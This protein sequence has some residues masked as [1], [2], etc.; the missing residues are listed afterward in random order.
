MALPAV[1]QI[2]GGGYPGQY[3]GGQY[4]GGQYPGGQYPGGR[5]PGGGYPGAGGGIPFPRRKKAPAKGQVDQQHPLQ[6]VSGAFRELDDKAITILTDDNLT[7]SAK[8]IEKT[9]FTKKG[10]ESADPKTWKPGDHVVIEATQDEQGFYY[11]VNVIFDRE[12]TSAEREAVAGPPP[13]TSAKAGEKETPVAKTEDGEIIRSSVPPLEDKPMDSDDPGRPRIR[14]GKPPATP[15]SPA[16]TTTAT[17]TASAAPPKVLGEWKPTPDYS[18]GESNSTTRTATPDASS[19]RSSQPV[20]LQEN[21]LIVKAKKAT[22]QWLESLPNYYCQELVARYISETRPANWQAQD[23]VSAALIYEK[24]KERYTDL[25]INNKPVKKN[26]EELNGSWSTGE[27][28]T[29]VNDLFSPA[30]DALFRVARTDTVNGREA[31]QFSFDVDQQNSHW[32]ITLASQTF[33]PAYK[34][35]IWIDKETGRPLRIEMQS[36]KIPSTFAVD[37]AEMTVDFEFIR[38]AEAKYLLPTHAEVLSCA[39]G[40]SMCSHNVID[41]RNYHKFEGQSTITFSDSTISYDQK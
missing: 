31:T 6:K 10:G 28:A 17:N 34:G 7:V 25:K 15:A 2:N 1:A 14:R 21:P 11:A 12:G 39:R 37:T 4:P 26:M 29:V 19:P 16:S 5:Y 36:R 38:I 33:F 27:F 20:E 24:G 3:P 13:P 30:T 8:R 41:F 40:N 32:R 23:I 18:K 9:T 22:D 35:S